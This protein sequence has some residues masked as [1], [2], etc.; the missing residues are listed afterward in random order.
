MQLVPPRVPNVVGGQTASSGCWSFSRQF[1][2]KRICQIAE[3]QYPG[4]QEHW[5]EKGGRY[6]KN[7]S[8]DDILTPSD[9][10]EKAKDGGSHD[11]RKN[12]S[13]DKFKI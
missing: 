6:I 4:E 12:G 2:A 8:C 9:T 3:N 13:H 11:L 7:Q 5:G 1:M 10:T